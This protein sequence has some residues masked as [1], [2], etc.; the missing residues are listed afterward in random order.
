MPNVIRKIV[1]AITLSVFSLFIG[2]GDVNNELEPITFQLD[3][4]LEIDENGYYR[5][6]LDMSNWQTLHRI[7]GHLYRN[8]RPMNVTKFG[9]SSNLYWL[10]GDTLGHVI[11]NN[12][13]TDDLVYVAYD[14]T[15]ITWFG[16]YEV[17][18]INGAS[19][20]SSTTSCCTYVSADEDCAGCTNENACNYNPT[21]VEDDGSCLTIY[22][23][24]DPNA[25]P[26]S[27]NPNAQC[28]D[29]SCTYLTTWYIDNDG[30]G[31][32]FDGLGLF[33]I[34]SCDEIEG[35]ADNNDD[36]NDGDFDND[37]ISSTEFNG[38]DCDDT[39]A[40]I[41]IAETG[42][43]CAGNCLQD[44]DNDGVCDAIYGCTDS[45][46][47]EYNPEA[48]DDDG[49][50]V[51]LMGCLDNNY[52]EYN[53]DAVVDNGTCLSKKGD[54]DG[55]DFVN[56]SDLFIVLDHWLQVTEAGQNGDVNQDEIVNL[57]DLF[58]VLDHWLQ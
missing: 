26:D 44:E 20:S 16:G 11:A 40:S 6:P 54:A 7:S 23:C 3:A 47:Q 8:G 4:R 53:A 24:T 45:N 28:D 48:T 30:D 29:G 43:D 35:Y 27:Y 58:D 41:G 17:P 5:L 51:T 31:L 32:G 37:G 21:A 52:Y 42:Y 50:C 2:C 56:L 15:Y 57:S 9:W 55:D 1:G 25:C 38:N 10:I 18:I 46:Y 36:E 19:Y 49:T 12:G 22:G 33:S 39:D 13:L 34:E 14:T